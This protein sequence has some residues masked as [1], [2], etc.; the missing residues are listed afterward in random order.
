M[1]DLIENFKHQYIYK[2]D[3]KIKKELKKLDKDHLYLNELNLK[4]NSI[5][6][7]LTSDSIPTM[8]QTRPLSSCSESKKA[9]E[10]NFFK[11]KTP[12]KS[13][14]QINCVSNSSTTCTK[15]GTATAIKKVKKINNNKFKSTEKKYKNF[16]YSKEQFIKFSKIPKELEKNCIDFISSRKNNSKK[17]SIDA[18]CKVQGIKIQNFKKLFSRFDSYK[19][20]SDRGK[21]K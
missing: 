19:C 20:Q 2:D 7:S 11:N 9:S 16:F 5:S 15:K 6:G 4:K 14:S 3:L 21:N 18:S 12:K 17:M 8:N 13:S 10:K 1:V